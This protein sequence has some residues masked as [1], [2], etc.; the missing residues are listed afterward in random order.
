[1]TRNSP[2]LNVRKK[3]TKSQIWK[4]PAKRVQNEGHE[5]TEKTQLKTNKFKSFCN[6]RPFQESFKMDWKSKVTKTQEKQ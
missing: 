3:T 4:N 2:I 5:E 6:M 1:M